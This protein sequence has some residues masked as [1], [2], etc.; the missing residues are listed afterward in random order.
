VLASP[1]CRTRDAASLAFGRF[2]S[3]RALLSAEFFPD[4]VAEE[5]QP[6]RLRR[7]LATRPRP[8]TNTILVSHGFAIGDASGLSLAEGEAV[9]VAP[10]RGARGFEVVSRAEAEGWARLGRGARPGRAARPPR[11]RLRKFKVFDGAGPRDVAPAADGNVW[12]T[13]QAAGELGRLDPRTGRVRRVPLGAGSA[14]H[15]VIVG[16]DWAAG[17]RRA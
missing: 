17:D 7:L 10:G 12:F 2:R 15:G 16:P 6:A 8:G 13:A 14:P 5:R 3:S 1:F 11:V 9:I 4:D